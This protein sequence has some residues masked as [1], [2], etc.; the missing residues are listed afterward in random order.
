M[1][2]LKPLLL[3]VLAWGLFVRSE[4]GTE[5]VDRYESRAACAAAASTHLQPVTE[6]DEQVRRGNSD[7]EGRD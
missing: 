3:I 2:S 5:M 6:R 1:R 7:M 4:N